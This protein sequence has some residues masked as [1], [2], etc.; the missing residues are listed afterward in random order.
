MMQMSQDE[1][2]HRSDEDPEDIINIR[3]H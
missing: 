1:D 3:C 2:E